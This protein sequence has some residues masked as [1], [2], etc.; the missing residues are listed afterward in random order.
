[1][2]ADKRKTANNDSMDEPLTEYQLK[3]RITWAAL[4][5]CVYEVDPLECPN[6]GGEMMIISF[7][8]AKTQADV[9]KRIL[10][11]CGLWKDIVL[12]APPI[13]T[14]PPVSEPEETQYD[15]TFFDRI[16]A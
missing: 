5:K 1:M 3:R 6:C 7:I 16:C 14:K 10:K 9:I 13:E 15:Y 8:E 12:R 4:I 11:H 2:R